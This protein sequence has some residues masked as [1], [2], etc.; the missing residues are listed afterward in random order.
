MV[1][2]DGG[3]TPLPFDL[4]TPGFATQRATIGFA[5]AAKLGR[6]AS[7][8]IKTDVFLARARRRRVPYRFARP[9]CQLAS[10]PRSLAR[11]LSDTP[12]L[13]LTELPWSHGHN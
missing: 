5:S 9:L 8:T 12:G 13:M 4:A 11:R 3:G 2:M 10:R 7:E 6:V 1:V